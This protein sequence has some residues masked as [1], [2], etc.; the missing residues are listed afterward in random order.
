M[1]VDETYWSAGYQLTAGLRGTDRMI[2]G[3]AYSTNVSEDFSALQSPSKLP[4]DRLTNMT[5]HFVAGRCDKRRPV[6][7][8][9]SYDVCMIPVGGKGKTRLFMS[10]LGQVLESFTIANSRVPPLG[11][12]VDGGTTNELICAA[13]CGL[14]SDNELVGGIFCL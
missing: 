8:T 14:L 1:A 3:G 11:F 6:P 12:A 4:S 7:S 9:P 13:G 5:V 2:V 10:V